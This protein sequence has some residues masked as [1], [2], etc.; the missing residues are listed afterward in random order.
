MD[1]SKGGGMP[2]LLPTF[3]EAS[4]VLS[5]TCSSL[6]LFSQGKPRFGWHQKSAGIKVKDKEGHSYW[7]RVS[8]HARYEN[9]W[10]ELLK[11]KDSNKIRGLS[12]PFVEKAWL[13]P[14]KEGY[15]VGI[16]LTYISESVC[17]SQAMLEEDLVLSSVWISSLKA[18]LD[19][20]ARVKTSHLSCTQN[21]F[22]RRLEERYGIRNSVIHR[23][24]TGHGDLNWSNLT[25][26]TP[27]ILD[28]EG[29]G[30]GP[31]GLDIA[32]LYC[33]ALKFPETAR[34]IRHSFEDW[35]LTRHGQLCVL[36]V[37]AELLRMIEINGDH[38]SLEKPLYRLI[39]SILY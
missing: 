30:V 35:F 36:F 32:F 21:L 17:S 13:E 8:W 19:A 11:I 16:L 37:G 5:S 27:W 7:L 39:E 9:A 10:G 23:W 22:S 1:R 38:P 15:E 2:F 26:R 34:Q 6:G 24:T 18:Q 20:L 29:W 12:K 3:Y 14:W 33:Y 31:Q 28:W 25:R 4:K